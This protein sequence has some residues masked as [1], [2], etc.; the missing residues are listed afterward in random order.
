MFTDKNVPRFWR[1]P[2]PPYALLGGEQAVAG[3]SLYF[4]SDL[5]LGD[6]T[7][8]DRFLHPE[9][10]LRLIDQIGSEPGGELVLVGDVLELWACEMGAVLARHGLII[11][12]LADLAAA[13]PVTYVVGNHDSVPFYLYLGARLGP[14]AVTE[15]FTARLAGDTLVAIHGHQYDPF[16]RVSL[17]AGRLR[18]P[19]TQRLVHLVGTLERHGFGDLMS[20][21]SGTVDHLMARVQEAE[22]RIAAEA[23]PG[24]E[25]KRRLLQVVREVMLREPPG[26]RDY[27]LGEERYRRAALDWMRQGARWVILG[28][29]HHPDRLAAGQRLYVN[30][31]CWCWDRYPPTYARWAAGELEL[32]NALDGRPYRPA[33]ATPPGGK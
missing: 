11:R 28:H 9:A 16:N 23:G 20:G 2:P 15:R 29:T 3:R 19:F 1:A 26:Q 33:A 31:G 27:P 18:T 13:R 5:H 32:Y 12:R 10:L 22:Q 30:T 24:G 17:E 6:G 7:G 14:V 25:L 21:G 8:A 4:I